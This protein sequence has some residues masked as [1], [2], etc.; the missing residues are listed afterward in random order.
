VHGHEVPAD[1]TA[2][3]LAATTALEDVIVQFDRLV[4][5]ATLNGLKR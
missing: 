2:L 1:G 5:A 3:A 4:I